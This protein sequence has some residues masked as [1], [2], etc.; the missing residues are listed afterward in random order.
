[1]NEPLS[2]EHRPSGNFLASSRSHKFLSAYT[3][4]PFT[5]THISRVHPM[6]TFL[7]CFRSEAIVVF[8][9]TMV[10]VGSFRGR[11]YT[12]LIFTRA[13]RSAPIAFHFSEAAGISL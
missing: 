3:S 8:S 11:P 6:S 7:V 4:F 12:R 5:K 9:H 1:M 2:S 13:F 10:R